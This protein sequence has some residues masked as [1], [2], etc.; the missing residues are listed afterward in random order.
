MGKNARIMELEK[1][2]EGLQSEIKTLK[3]AWVF[4]RELSELPEDAVL[5]YTR[6]NMRFQQEIGKAA[7]RF[8]ENSPL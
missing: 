6:S 1:Q 8:L 5:L 3:Q 4:I 7:R 2:I